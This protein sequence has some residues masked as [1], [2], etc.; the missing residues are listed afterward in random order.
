MESSGK[1]LPNSDQFCGFS[2][3]CPRGRLLSIKHLNSKSP[4]SNS[5]AIA[6][7]VVIGCIFAIVL[8]L[9]LYIR[10]KKLPHCNNGGPK[11]T[12]GKQAES[13]VQENTKVT[14]RKPRSNE[15]AI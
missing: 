7:P 11:T 12:E 6:I 13:Y 8:T 2:E 9:G 14:M 15:L 5:V 4:T 3:K 1:L 10:R